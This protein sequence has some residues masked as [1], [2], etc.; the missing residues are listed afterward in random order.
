ME[1]GHRSE[2]FIETVAL[3]EGGG[4]KAPQLQPKRSGRC[5]VASGWNL[6][7]YRLTCGRRRAKGSDLGTQMNACKREKGWILPPELRAE[8]AAF[9]P[10]FDLQ[11]FLS[12]LRSESRSRRRA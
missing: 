8:R 4:P 11:E 3:L 12:T 2:K 6:P 7:L 10:Y 1:F 5:A 9:G